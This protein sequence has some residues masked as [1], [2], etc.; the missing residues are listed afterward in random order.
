[1]L[2]RLHV[3]LHCTLKYFFF[4]ARGNIYL[5]SSSA[6]THFDIVV[7]NFIRFLD[8]SFDQ[9]FLSPIYKFILMDFCIRRQRST[10]S[11]N[12]HNKC[13]LIFIIN[14][15]QIYK[16]YEFYSISHSP[17]QISTVSLL[18]VFIRYA[19]TYFLCK[20]HFVYIILE[21]NWLYKQSIIQH[22]QFICHFLFY[23]YFKNCM[24]KT[25]QAFYILMTQNS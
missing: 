6:D 22:F 8:Y 17:V 12:I 14:V 13:L 19:D 23:Q 16:C 25:E 15:L 2:H 4:F 20:V 24:R 5:P 21:E 1:M 11:Y 7:N 18:T 3:I 9:L 10:E